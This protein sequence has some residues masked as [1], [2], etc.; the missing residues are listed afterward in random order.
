MNEGGGRGCDNF[1]VHY[2]NK[3]PTQDEKTGETAAAII[4]LRG[5]AAQTRSL[6]VRV[7]GA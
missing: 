1:L 5:G 6:I 7:H 4:H 3:L 2:A